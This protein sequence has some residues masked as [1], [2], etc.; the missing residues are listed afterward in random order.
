MFTGSEN[1][2]QAFKR[3]IILARVL[4]ILFCNP[5]FWNLSGYEILCRLIRLSTRFQNIPV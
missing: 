2:K 3:K 1:E 5:E 4:A